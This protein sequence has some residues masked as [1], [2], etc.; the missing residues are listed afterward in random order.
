MGDESPAVSNDAKPADGIDLPPE[1]RDAIDRFHVLRQDATHYELL[2]VAADA[3]RKVIRDAYFALSKRFHPDVY[4]K[5]EI[6]NYREK[7]EGIF[8]AI[9][10]AYDALSN[11]RQRAAYDKLLQESG[12]APV[13]Q[14]IAPPPTKLTPPRITPPAGLREAAQQA[15][16]IIA[17]NGSAPSKSS[18]SNPAI[19]PVAGTIPPV[20]PT[21]PEGVVVPP[22]LRTLTEAGPSRPTP[23]ASTSSS[24][25]P[26]VDESVRQRALE[27]MARRLGVS[28]R[29]PA[30]TSTTPPAISAQQIL[31]ER[32]A[33]LASLVAKAEESQKAGD[34][35]AAL[36]GYK[37]ALQLSKDD[38]TITARVDAISQLL[39]AQQVADHIEKAKQATRDRDFER[40]AMLWEKA[41]DGR[42]EDASLLLNAAELLAKAKDNK[43]AAELAQRAIGIDPKVVRAHVVLANVFLEAGLKASA[44]GAIENLARLEPNHPQLKELKEKVGPLTIAEQFG[45]RGSR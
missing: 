24:S 13:T 23:I 28:G 45:L 1:E 21:F 38:P 6:G 11:P 32:K 10:R 9:T 27:A 19:T 16:A 4:F 35:Q 44:R 26:V 36:D 2:G 34:L 33:R 7:V 12:V 25:V 3:D 22:S 31:D 40:A 18:A 8:R 20:R 5:R 39:R 42:R 15:R 14:S 17:G 29:K 43:R 37:A 30:A 41:W